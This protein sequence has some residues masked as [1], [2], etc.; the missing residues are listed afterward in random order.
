MYWNISWIGWWPGRQPYRYVYIYTYTCYACMC[1]YKYLSPCLPIELTVFLS[2]YLSIHPS[3]YI[4]IHWNVYMIGTNYYIHIPIDIH[5]IKALPCVH[6]RGGLACLTMRAQGQLIGS[7]TRSLQKIH[8]FWGFHRNLIWVYEISLII[9]LWGLSPVS[10]KRFGVVDI[11]E[12]WNRNPTHFSDL[13]D[14][15]RFTS[16]SYRC[17]ETGTRGRMKTIF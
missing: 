5:Q 2:I 6:L 13:I 11:I 8:H 15:T 3:S 1:T 10:M 7:P 9:L 4:F 12:Q 14:G 16:F 17:Y